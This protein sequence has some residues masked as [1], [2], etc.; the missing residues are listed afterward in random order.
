MSRRGNEEGLLGIAFHPDY[1]A[2]GRLFVCY[3]AEDEERKPSLVLSGFQREEGSSLAASPQ[4]EE[5]ILVVPQPFRT[6]N[7]GSLEFGPDGFLYV[8][9]GDGGSANDPQ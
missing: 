7:G 3:S 4:F 2:N 5:Q 9:L 6:Q 8:G 1:Q